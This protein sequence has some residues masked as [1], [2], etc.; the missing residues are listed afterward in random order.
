M[1]L[2]PK[3]KYKNINF[4]TDRKSIVDQAV[5]LVNSYRLQG[6]NLT[7]RQLY[8][9]FVSRN[10]FP[11]SWG[12]KETGS[13]NNERSYKKLGDIIA[14]ARLAGIVDWHAIEDRTRNVDG[15]N[16]WT[17]PA[18]VV[19]ACANQFQLDKWTTQKYRVEVWVEK[20][21]LEGVVGKAAKAMDVA[22]FSCRGY[23]SMTSMWDAGQRLKGH[24]CHGQIPVIL[25]LGDHDPSGIDMSRD[26]EDRVSMF[27]D[28]HS[29]K[30]IFNRIALNRPQIDQYSPP[31][32][33]AKVTDS[34]FKKYQDEHGD[35]SYELDALDPAV[36]EELIRKHISKYRNETQFGKRK[37]EEDGHRDNLRKAAE[38]W[39]GEV[40]ELLETLD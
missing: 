20:D 25:H 24:A 8:Y 17:N 34:R 35:D 30:L 7:L 36:I 21:A 4:S 13:T 29:E 2:M 9:Q 3:I 22:F 32:N 14:D 1:K 26:I 16:H 23:A 40:S 18:E 10:I 28:E 37:D 33:P 27:M 38:N 5:E 6:Y 11:E 15:N 39:N 31:P 19:R 12:D